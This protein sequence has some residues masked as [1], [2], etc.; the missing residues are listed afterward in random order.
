MT[1]T[2]MM[3]VT[4]LHTGTLGTT[5]TTMDEQGQK[6]EPTTKMSNEQASATDLSYSRPSQ[7]LVRQSSSFRRPYVLTKHQAEIISAAQRGDLATVR[8]LVESG[9]ATVNDRDDQNV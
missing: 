3:L 5:A 2:S 6:G 8:E 9:N 7:P 1:G 4:A